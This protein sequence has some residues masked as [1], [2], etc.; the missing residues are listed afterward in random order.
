M[1]TIL[2]STFLWGGFSMGAIVAGLFFLRFYRDTRDRFFLIFALAFWVLALDRLFLTVFSPSNEN[3]HYVYLMR[4][5]AF[6]LIIGG[7]IDKN[8]SA[9]RDG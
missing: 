9:K 1:N 8:R 3:Q 6:L 4:L 5:T 7:I 2:L